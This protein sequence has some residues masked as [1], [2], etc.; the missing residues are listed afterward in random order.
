MKINIDSLIIIILVC[1]SVSTLVGCATNKTDSNQNSILKVVDIGPTNGEKTGAKIIFNQSNFYTFTNPH[2]LTNCS[3]DIKTYFHLFNLQNNTPESYPENTANTAKNLNPKFIKNISLDLTDYTQTESNPKAAYC[4]LKNESIFN[5]TNLRCASFRQ[6]SFQN[7][8]F[9]S[10]LDAE[11]EKL[12]PLQSSASSLNKLM[13]GGVYI[14][15]DRSFLA[16]NENLI[17]H[18]TYLPL[19]I[20]LTEDSDPTYPIWPIFR[21]H[22]LQTGESLADLENAFQPRN[23]FYTSDSNVQKIAYTFAVLSPQ[24]QEVREDQIF[25]PLSMNPKVDRIQIERYSGSAML[26]EASLIRSGSV[27]SPAQGGAK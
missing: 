12:G 6:S 21:I 2:P 10:F 5:S 3:G 8:G 19:P 11:C 23:L 13:A 17:L 14:D 22:L 24:T 9:Y 18:L 15:L 7:F 26:L 27:Y 20:I 4:L 1:I 16:T 25:I